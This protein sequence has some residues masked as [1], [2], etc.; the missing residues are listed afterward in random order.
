MIVSEN[1][2]RESWGTP[3]AAIGKRFRQFANMPWMEVVGVVQDVHHNGVDEKAPAIVYWPAMM[4]DPYIPN[5]D[6]CAAR[7]NLCDSERSSGNEGFLS[8]V[9]QA[10][11]S[12]NANLPLARFRPCRRS[13]ASRWRALRS[14]W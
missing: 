2:A 10:V 3:A 1:F 9:Q 11:W 8:E 7:S 13:T 5:H 12:V 4:D 6:R 14:P